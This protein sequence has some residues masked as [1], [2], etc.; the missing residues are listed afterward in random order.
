[1]VLIHLLFLPMPELLFNFS[2][3]MITQEINIGSQTTISV[4]LKSDDKIMQEVVVVGYGT[5][6]RRQ[7][8]VLSVRSALTILLPCKSEYWI[9]N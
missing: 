4:T 9:N 6:Q 2:V 8:T 5:Q 7:A 1:M 3:D